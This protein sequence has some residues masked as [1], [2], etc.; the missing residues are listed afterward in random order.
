MGK[1]GFGTAEKLPSG[2][3]RAYYSIG[4]RG[5]NR[6]INAPGTFPS[7]K[8]ARLW[9]AEQQLALA[10]GTWVDPQTVKPSHAPEQEQAA[11]SWTF[12]GWVEEYFR[13]AE[14][15][16][17]P[18]SIQSYKSNVKPAL[19]RFGD[20]QL[21]EISREDVEAWWRDG[22][23]NG[24]W[25]AR[26]H[27]HILSIVFRAAVEAGIIAE[28]PAQVK[29]A[30]SKPKT[31]DSPRH[32][33]ATPEQVARIVEAMPVEWRI[34]V[35]LGFWCQLRFG[36]IRELRRKDIDLTRREV[37]I[38]R[39]VQQVAGRGY[40]VGPPKSAAGVR[41]ISIP[42]NVMPALEEHLRLRVGDSPDSLLVHA[43]GSPSYWLS[44]TGFHDRYNEAVKGVE[45]LDSRFTFHGLRHSGL[46]LLGQCGATLAEL[47]HR[48]GHSDVERVI[49]YQHSSRERDAALADKLAGM[50]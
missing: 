18:K 26:N 14:T 30:R 27:Y 32:I 42:P 21:G 50:A 35:L 6:R 17:A 47:M 34:C 9:L 22:Q 48:A 7:L 23:H 11:V 8:A 38:T 12:A 20:K 29:G 49:I 2:N 28:S 45:G 19:A 43:K 16:L 13:R 1:S 10:N 15:R 25:G 39:G 37:S 3:Y 41:T 33:V 31:I 36:E 24:K 44:S 5:R 46:T 4:E 40:I